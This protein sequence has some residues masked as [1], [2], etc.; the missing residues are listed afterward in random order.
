MVEGARRASRAG[1]TGSPDHS[2]G[3]ANMVQKGGKAC[4]M[5][6]LMAKVLSTDIVWV[7]NFFQGGRG[8]T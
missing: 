7:S 5:G 8:Q 6:T 2:R 3:Q 4:N 1:P